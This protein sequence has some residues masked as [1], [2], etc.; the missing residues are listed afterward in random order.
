MEINIRHIINGNFISFLDKKNSSTSGNKE[1]QQP[2]LITGGTKSLVHLKLKLSLLRI[3]IQNYSSPIDWI[4]GLKFL[5][6]LRRKFLGNHRLSKMALV[7]GKYYMGLFTPGW[8]D[9]IYKRFI[10]SELLAFKKSEIKGFR[11][12]NVF[13]AITKKCALQCE[14]CYEWE[15]LNKKEFLDEH[16]LRRIIGKLQEKGVA[17]IHFTGGEPMIKFDLLIHLLNSAKK[18]SHFWLDTSGY[19]LSLEKA[20]LLKKSGLTGV[21]ISLD[22]YMPE[23]H[24]KFRHFKDAFYWATTAAKNANR[25]GLVACFSLCLR[26]EFVTEENLLNYMKFARDLK[27][28]F[29][30]FLEPKT[31]GHYSNKNVLLPP[32]TLELIESFFLKMNFSKGYKDYPIIC[33]HGYYQRRTGCFAAGKK[34][35]YI[36]TDGE[37]N[38]CPFCH[39]KTGNILEANFED[40]LE[41]QAIRG[42]TEFS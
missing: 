27:V 15:N 12:N 26:K 23:E 34:G 36:D 24:N 28:P 7:S 31:V 5:V 6:K 25:T 4:N 17:Q 32:E 37:I 3:L 1:I 20:R 35:I 16:K 22:H 18:E 13:L 10:S 11:L 2:L 33:Y 21:L 42:C 8:N 14:H 30:Q 40:S 41:Q 39:Y 38:S 29:V 19:Q 9:E